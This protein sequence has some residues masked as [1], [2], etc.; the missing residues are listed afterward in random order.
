MAKDKQDLDA[1]WKHKSDIN[2]KNFM[3]SQHELSVENKRLEAQF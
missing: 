1:K 3:A 2:T